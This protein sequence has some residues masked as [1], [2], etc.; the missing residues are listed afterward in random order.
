[1]VLGTF[2]WLKTLKNSH[3]RELIEDFKS[4]VIEQTAA[5]QFIKPSSSVN[6]PHPDKSLVYR[7]LPN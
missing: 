3:Q 5:A 1:L 4:K 6:D 2:Y 7:S